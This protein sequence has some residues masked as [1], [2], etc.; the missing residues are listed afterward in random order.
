M[1]EITF[2]H[3]TTRNHRRRD[4]WMQEQTEENGVQAKVQKRCVYMVKGHRHFE[5]S[6]DLEEW[7][8]GHSVDSQCRLRNLTVSR[9]Q[10]THANTRQFSFKAIGSFYAVVGEDL[11]SIAFVQTYRVDLQGHPDLLKGGSSFGLQ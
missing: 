8:K 1:R 7:L 5:A 11:Y 10:D 6:S 2:R 3:L 4:L 9:I